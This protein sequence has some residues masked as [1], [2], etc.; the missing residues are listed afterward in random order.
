MKKAELE[1]LFREYYPEMYQRALTILYD[2]QE[3]DDVVCGIFEVLLR[4]DMELLPDRAE[5]YLLKSV[6][7]ECLKRIHQKSNRERLM[8]FYAKERLID[9][10]L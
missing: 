2:R 1:R 10:D 9:E 4:Q 3:S 8:Q 5:P 6:R 7:N